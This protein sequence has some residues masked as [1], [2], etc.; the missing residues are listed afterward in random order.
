MIDAYFLGIDVGTQ[1][2]RV[3]ICDSNGRL[4]KTTSRAYR[5]FFPKPGWAEQEPSD[6]W[7]AVCESTRR[8]VEE[9]GIK[10]SD[11]T[12]ISF[13]ATSSTV[14]AVNREGSSLDR[15]ILWMDQRAVQEVED[16]RKTGHPRLKYSGGQDSAE[17][18]VPKALW[19]KRNRP[20]QFNS[21]FFIIEAT[22]WIAYKLTG[23][24]T[25]S[26]CNATCK[27]NYVSREGG[28]DRDFLA[29][30]G[31]MNILDKWPERVA[32]LGERIGGLDRKASVELGLPEGI[33]VAEGGVD[34]HVGLLGLNALN[35]GNIGMI[36][37]SSNVFFILND[38]PVF[39]PEFWGPYPDAVL[40]G[41]WL[42]EGGQTSSG[43]IVNWLVD[44]I[45][46]ISKNREADRNQILEKLEEL[47]SSVPSCSEGVIT[48]DYW[49]GNRTPR[50]DP[51]AKG[52][53]FGLSLGH[54]FGHILRSV[55]EGIS[56]GTKH[57]MD[58]WKSKGVKIISATAG[59]GGT[60]SKLWLR[61]LADICDLPITVPMYADSCGIIGSAVC[62]AYGS[63][64]YR[65]LPE[66]AEAMVT[67]ERR[68]TPTGEAESFERA[69]RNY[70]ELYEKTKPLL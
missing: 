67:E 23:N 38:E 56:F 61:L 69:Y 48:L 47:A 70:L 26:K 10:P 24:W 40:D 27:W 5:T 31:L 28:W 58:S 1:S 15:A 52:I 68:I 36:L 63:G 9:S 43:S 64:V 46:E 8:C 14:L 50:R 34:A 49:Q 13:D 59:G 18:M 17:W 54:T 19:L 7:K 41:K 29:E 3:G 44:N 6:W 60:K 33:P 2:A 22:D 62:A 4:I 55:Y 37:G 16:I 57:I 51:R 65:S 11:I 66:A 53:I 21:A 42:L 39:S 32:S 30:I 35:P 12:G 20:E 25:V 45:Y